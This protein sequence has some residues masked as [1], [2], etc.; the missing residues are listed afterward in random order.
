M[1]N[2]FP[3]A[4][5]DAP[6]V[7]NCSVTPIPGSGSA[8]LQVIANSGVRAAYAIDYLDSTA[9]YIGV[10]TGPAN[11]ETLRCIIGGGYGTRANVVIPVHSR[12]SVRSLTT[13]AITNGY[14]SMTLMGM[15]LV[16]P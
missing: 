2:L 13:S 16:I 6:R 8:P 15:G 10:F 1:D 3:V 14:I 4:Y 7:L 5:L 12:V 9:D 11:S